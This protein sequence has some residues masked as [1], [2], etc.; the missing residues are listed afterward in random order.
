MITEEVKTLNEV[1]ALSA[2]ATK[3]RDQFLKFG[4]NWFEEL[5]FQFTPA[6]RTV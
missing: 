6:N 2:S 4:A 1:L 5:Y 3:M